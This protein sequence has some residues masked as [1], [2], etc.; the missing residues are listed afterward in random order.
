MKKIGITT[1]V[2]IEVLMAAGYTPIDLNN[3]FIGSPECESLVALAE[4][5]GF[6][7]NCC[8][9]IKGIYGVCLE[10]GVKTVLCVTNGD[11]S[12]TGMLMEVLRLKGLETIPFAYPEEPDPAAMRRALEGL[13]DRLG[14]TLDAAWDVRAQLG[15]ARRLAHELDRRTWQDGT[16]SGLE[17]HRWLV[18]ASDF[19]G[20]HREYESRLSTL[21]AA[22]DARDSFPN[23]YLRLAYV[24]VPPVFADE[25][26][27]CIERNRAR[28]VLNEIQ[29]QFAMTDQGDSLAGQYC[30]Y[31]YPYSI[32]GRVNDI[33]TEVGRRKVDGVIHYVQAFCHR[34]IG[35]IILRNQID[36]PMLTLE[37]NNDFSL[38]NHVRTRIE[39]F[40]DM[41]RRRRA[42]K[43][44]VGPGADA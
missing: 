34:G 44:A 4:R 16:V 9:W 36:L 33:R 8:A 38:S 19:G 17:N 24:G 20:D 2:P 18:T 37:G 29:R 42:T 32:M 31:T 7:Q 39:A 1:T 12:N 35:D 15:R 40:I 14:T 28:V 11:C 13:A 30:N 3:M 27:P 5:A 26:Y 22:M 21:L 23:D 43:G 41:L 10:Y 25:L 6:P